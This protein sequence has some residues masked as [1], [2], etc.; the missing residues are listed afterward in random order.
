MMLLL[1]LAAAAHAAP[2]TESE[3]QEILLAHN[4]ERATVNPPAADMRRLVWSDELAASASDYADRCIFQHP[5]DELNEL[6]YGENLALASG[7]PTATS[8]VGQ[9]LSEE[10]DWT[11]AP[12]GQDSAT[13]GV[14]GHYTQI[15]WADTDEVGCGTAVCEEVQFAFPGTLTV[16]R[17]NRGG[18]YWNAY[19][20]ESGD[21]CSSCPSGYMCDA[22]SN[23]CY[24]PNNLGDAPQPD[25][26]L[27][28]ESEIELTIARSGPCSGDVSLD[29]TVS[30]LPANDNIA[31]VY[32]NQLG[33]FSIPSSLPCAGTALDVVVSDHLVGNSDASGTYTASLGPFPSVVCNMWV[34]ALSLST[35]EVSDAVNIGA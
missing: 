32:G 3:I 1:A 20:Y 21:G 12:V 22:E 5:Q 13:G 35:C 8:T 29:V 27:P 25:L 9:W 28:G 6:G 33:A 31:L 17:Y 14:V 4:Y 26:N 19:P 10:A 15:V 7:S 11:Y 23:L 24:D 2:V 18:N 34:Q 30:G 16:C